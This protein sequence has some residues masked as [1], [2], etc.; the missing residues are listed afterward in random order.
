MVCF[1]S[2]EHESCSKQFL[3]KN[4]E[5]SETETASQKKM[6]EILDKYTMEDD[7][8]DDDVEKEPKRQWKYVPPEST[9]KQIE[10]LKTKFGFSGSKKNTFE[11]EPSNDSDSDKTD[12]ELTAQEE[13]ELEELVNGATEEQLLQILSPE[14]LRQFQDLIENGYYEDADSDDDY[15]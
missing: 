7:Q 9:A 2:P 15:E 11:H 3:K 1:K 10:E 6:L 12:H 14:Q 4:V 8:Q 13:R 5:S